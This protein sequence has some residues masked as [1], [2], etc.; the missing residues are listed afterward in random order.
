MFGAALAEGAVADWA[1]IF[2]TERF[3]LT[4]A[5][6]LGSFMIFSFAMFFG[7]ILAD[8]LV[9]RYGAARVC[10]VGGWLSTIGISF[11][12]LEFRFQHR[13]SRIFACLA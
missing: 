9:D 2:V 1:A 8:G 5:M 7:R 4:E 3:T 6:A 13:V 10:G 11:I 12:L